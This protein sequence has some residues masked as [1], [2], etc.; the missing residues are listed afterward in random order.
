MTNQFMN[1]ESN[2]RANRTYNNS[3]GSTLVLCVLS[4]Y[5][6]CRNICLQNITSSITPSIL[7][8]SIRLINCWCLYS[9]ITAGQQRGSLPLF[10]DNIAT[11]E[12]IF[13]ED[14]GD[15]NGKRGEEEEGQD[16]EGFNPLGGDDDSEELGYT[17]GC[18]KELVS[19][20][21]NGVRYMSYQQ[22]KSTR[23]SQESNP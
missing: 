13:A 8:H 9:V 21:S 5:P 14:T 11:L 19:R 2:Y 6:I 20:W 3:D 10:T 4:P 22:S 7:L 16:C 18:G 1:E 23:Q 15:S 17:E 12:R